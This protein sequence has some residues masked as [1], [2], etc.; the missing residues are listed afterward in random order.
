MPTPLPL[1]PGHLPIR[2]VLPTPHNPPRPPPSEDIPESPGELYPLDA[3]L[4][5]RL[6]LRLELPVEAREVPSVE[7]DAGD[8]GDEAGDAD[9][10]RL[11]VGRPPRRG[12]DVGAADVA[13]L[14]D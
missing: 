12:E 9:R 10:V 6:V 1:I 8:A 14:G 11:L 13:K 3:V 7:E 2:P 5:A 4:D